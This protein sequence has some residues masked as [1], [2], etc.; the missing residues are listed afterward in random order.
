MECVTKD[1]ISNTVNEVR[2]ISFEEKI[3]SSEEKINSFLDAILDFKNNLIEKSNKIIELADKLEQ[4][5]W[6]TVDDNECLMLL[7]DL[8]AQSKDLHSSLIRNYVVFAPLRQKGIAKDEIR[9]YKSAIDDF[10]E[11][12]ID[13]ESVFFFLP[14]IPEFKETTRELS[15][16]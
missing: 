2:Q 14:E 6:L 8:I 1:K 5:T 11:S 10:K 12:Y 15:L 9:T 4:I 16:V 13:L 7:N 3:N